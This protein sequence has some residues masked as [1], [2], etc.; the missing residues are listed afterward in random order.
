MSATHHIRM[1]IAQRTK[2]TMSGQY[3]AMVSTEWKTD[4]LIMG[5]YCNIQRD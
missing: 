4:Q 5:D 1:T 2:D 3:P